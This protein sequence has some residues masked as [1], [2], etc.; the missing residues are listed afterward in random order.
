[1]EMKD[2]KDSVSDIKETVT[3]TIKS[4]DKESVKG[5][6]EKL[7]FRKYAEKVPALSKV[8]PYAN[9]I[10]AGIVAILL[11]VVL[12]NVFGGES[13][14]VLARESLDLMIQA[15]SYRE[16]TVSA[17]EVASLVKRNEALQRKL[18]KLSPSQ[19]EAFEVEY[20]RLAAQILLG[21]Y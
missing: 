8:A 17:S 9:H 13:P 7:P 5:F 19:A 12:A 16:K 14:E 3:E 15:D 4:V 18:K 6:F 11:I 2:F 20:K 21:I 1:M 10:G